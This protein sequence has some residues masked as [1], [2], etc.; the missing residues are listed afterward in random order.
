MKTKIDE[1]GNGKTIQT[2][3]L[4]EGDF[5]PSEAAD[6]INAVLN[7]KINFHKLQR[8]SRTEGDSGDT[9]EYDNNRIDELLTSQEN[10]KAF[11]KKIRQEGGKINIESIISIDITK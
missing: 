8:L 10:A 6:V 11:F 3:K 5:T 2:I 7:V 9:C 4:I 1:S